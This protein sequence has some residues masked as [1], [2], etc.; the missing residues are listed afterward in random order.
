MLWFYLYQALLP[1][2]LAF[3]YPQWHIETGNLLWWLPLLGTL[4]FT[5]M[6]WR[7]KKVWGRPL[8]FAWGFF[9][10][11]LMPVMGLTDVGF[12]KYSLV[13]DRYQHIAIIGVIA[14]V[15]APWNIWRKRVHGGAHWSSA[16]VAIVAL[17]T[18]AFLTWRQSGFYS[19][20]ITLYQKT[21][22]K[23]PECWLAHNNLG[24]A[25]DNVGRSREAIE[26]YEQALRL[27]PG[28]IK[29]LNNLG[30][31][32]TETG[33]PRE[34]ILHLQQALVQN[35]D[36]IEAHYNLGN[37]LQA[38]GQYQQAIDQYQKALQI[39]PDFPEVHNNLGNSF[40]AVGQYQQALEHYNK[41]LRLKPD[42]IE[43][44]N[45][46]GLTLVQTGRTE[47]A[48]EHY[49]QALRLKPDFAQIQF[50]LALAYLSMHQSSLA[51]TTAQK[52][53]EL[54]RSKGQTAIAKQIEDWLTAHPAGQ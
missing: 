11:A 14:L 8:L 50:N 39:E 54:A 47:E 36:Y 27:K 37:A 5:A 12:M 48:I 3:I 46:L 45:N 32:L 43:A 40:K 24:L 49:Q 23:N 9:C 7:Y 2:D 53:L 41:A 35:P 22:E 42:Y 13:A 1:V 15:A 30:V 26:H 19:D 6:L 38:V 25:L 21:L 52:A 16:A 28:H 10:V 31:T 29:A 44:L 51:I 18:L 33:R 17:G 20:P 34:A 4:V